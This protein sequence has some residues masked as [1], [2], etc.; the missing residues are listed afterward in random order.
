MLEYIEILCTYSAVLIHCT[1]YFKLPPN[2]N[3]IM[4]MMLRILLIVSVCLSYYSSSLLLSTHSYGARSF[5]RGLAHSCSHASSRSVGLRMAPPSEEPNQ[6]PKRETS[7]GMLPTVGL[8][9]D[10]VGIVSISVDIYMS[11]VNAQSCV[12]IH[13]MLYALFKS[14]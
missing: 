12:V 14:R 1:M 2:N 7:P 4:M 13:H 6:P 11:C 9:K 8:G 5:C 3:H 10:Q